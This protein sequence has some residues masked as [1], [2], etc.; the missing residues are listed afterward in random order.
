MGEAVVDSELP[1][2]RVDRGPPKK[3]RRIVVSCIECHRRKQKVTI[4][5]SLTHQPRVVFLIST[6]SRLKSTTD[7]VVFARRE[8]SAIGSYLVQ[9]AVQGIGKHSAAMTLV[10]Q[11]LG[12]PI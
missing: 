4:I 3:R 10:L 11:L 5:S 12:I 6:E 8:I 2:S 1:V 7:I 9:T